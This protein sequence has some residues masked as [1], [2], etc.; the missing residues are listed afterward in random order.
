MLTEAG[1][2]VSFKIDTQLLQIV[3]GQLYERECLKE[4]VN[5]SPNSKQILRIRGGILVAKSPVPEVES[6]GEVIVQAETYLKVLWRGFMFRPELR[7][8]TPV[9]LFFP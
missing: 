8:Q 4:L 1:A 7:H 6:V 3:C 9:S 2:W 5:R